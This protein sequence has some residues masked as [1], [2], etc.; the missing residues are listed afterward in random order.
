[1]FIFGII[2]G[3]VLGI[4]VMVCRDISDLVRYFKR[5]YEDIRMG[6]FN[7][8]GS[9]GGRGSILTLENEQLIKDEELEI[10]K[11]IYGE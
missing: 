1:M 2:I 11:Q 9:G 3:V 4:M 5:Y 8:R 10:S 7:K 6:R